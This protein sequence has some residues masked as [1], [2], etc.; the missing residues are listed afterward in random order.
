MNVSKS[1][2]LKVS[3]KCR[4]VVAEKSIIPVKRKI[5][6]KA[7]ITPIT[8]ELSGFFL[9]KYAETMGTITTLSPVIKAELEAVV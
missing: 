8:E 4:P 5:P 9:R 7:R 3:L 2:R 6:T 1:P